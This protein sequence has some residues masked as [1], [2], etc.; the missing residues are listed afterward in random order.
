MK[1]SIQCYLHSISFLNV[2]SDLLEAWQVLFQNPATSIMTGIINLHLDL[3]FVSWMIVRTVILFDYKIHLVVFLI[4]LVNAFY[5]WFVNL[6]G[7]KV[8]IVFLDR[9][10]SCLYNYSWRVFSMDFRVYFFI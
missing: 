5:C 9:F 6:L 1:N 3:M 2:V 4:I 10:K 7:V 8:N